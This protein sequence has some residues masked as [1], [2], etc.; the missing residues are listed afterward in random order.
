MNGICRQQLK[1]KETEKFVLK[2][3]LAN[4]C[5]IRFK[6]LVLVIKSIVQND[7]GIGLIYYKF[8]TVSDL[9]LNPIISNSF[10]AYLCSNLSVKLKIILL[11]SVSHTAI[12]F[13]LR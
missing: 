1:K 11:N 7:S 6:G 4:S 8:E 3:D 5:C 9:Y 2:M 13:Q 12:Q 10:G